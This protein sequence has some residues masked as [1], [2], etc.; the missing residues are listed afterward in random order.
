ML[1][2]PLQLW[3]RPHWELKGR[4]DSAL[5]FRHLATA[6]PSATTLFVEGTSVAPEVDGFLRSV[7]EPGDY[8]PKRQTLWP[9][10]RQY[11]IRCDSTTLA[12]LADLAE[13]HAEPELLGHL[14]VYASSKVLLE[15]PDAFA[16][17]CPALISADN[18]EQTI[19]NFAVVLGLDM[20]RVMPSGRQ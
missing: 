8:L 3:N 5:F 19:R 18:D 12:A 11:R 15:F 6:F 10:P 1:G 17:G 9:R 14:F 13:E 16:G 7:A 2:V 4:I 20:I